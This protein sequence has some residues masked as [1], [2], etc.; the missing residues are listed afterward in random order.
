MIYLIDYGLSNKILN[1]KTNEHIIFSEGKSLIGTARFASINTHLGFEQ[2][3]RDDLESLGYLLVY[4]YCGCLPW[5]GT[6]VKTKTE[7]YNK[8]LELKLKMVPYEICKFLPGIYLIYIIMYNFL[9]YIYYKFFFF[10]F[11]LTLYR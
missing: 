7:K 2:S 10:F 5:Q 6:K 1:P 4:L 8:I 3:R 11:F 9:Y